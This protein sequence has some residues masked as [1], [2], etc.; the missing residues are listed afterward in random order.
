MC[1]HREWESLRHRFQEAVDEGEWREFVADAVTRV[2]SFVEE[3]RSRARAPEDADWV[4]G[5]G[6]RS[7]TEWV[8]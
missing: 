7:R 2:E 1:S 4:R 5:C 6:R 8:A 3:L